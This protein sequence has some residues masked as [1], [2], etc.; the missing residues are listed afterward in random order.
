MVT[1]YLRAELLSLRQHNNDVRIYRDVRKSLFALNLWLPLNDRMRSTST[2]RQQLID[3]ASASDVQ[4]PQQS[5][6][7]PRTPRRLSSAFIDKLTGN[8]GLLRY[9]DTQVGRLTHS[10]RESRIKRG[11]QSCVEGTSA[12]TNSFVAQVGQLAVRPLPS[13]PTPSP[14][15]LY[16]FNARSIAKPHAIEQLTAELIG[17]DVD[18]AV[19]SET[20]LKPNK[21]NDSVVNV[22]G[23]NLFRRDRKGRKGGG[24]AMY[25]RGSM[26]TTVWITPDLDSVFEMLWVKVSR[27]SDVTFVGALY[28]PPQPLYRTSELINII[29]AT[30]VKIHRD[31]PDSH[32]IL[33]GDFNTML[34]NDVV[35]ATGLTS[36]VQQPTRGNN[37]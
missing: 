9:R 12:A 37:D 24:V 22:D 4:P 31:Y 29:E 13:L 7:V 16:V 8:D 3:S 30:T 20:H 27:G 17:Y 26:C 21:H 32:I 6:T 11:S 36:V 28:H 2:S 14:P 34:D 10:H 35:I 5:V 25:V 19:V 33:A 23:Y 1:R 18:I 15:T